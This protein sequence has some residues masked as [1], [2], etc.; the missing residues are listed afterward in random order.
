MNVMSDTSW[1]SILP[2][3]VAIA[4]AIRSKQVYIS[5]F[6]GVYL[7][8]I[9]LS[10]WNPLEGAAVSLEYLIRVFADGGN[11]SI[12]LFCGLVGGL[13]ALTQHSGGVDGFV[14]TL[15]RRGGL[16]NRRSAQLMSGIMGTM[17]FVETSISSLVVGAVSR[18]VFDRM[19][20]SREK[21]AFIC[22][23][24]CAPINLLIP[25]NAWGAFIIGLLAKENIP[26]PV[27]VLITSLGFNFYALAAVTIVFILILTGK[28]F[29]PMKKAEQRARETGKVQADDAKPVVSE[30]VI[31][32]KRAP[33]IKPAASNML[34]P[35]VTMILMMPVGLLVTGKGDLTA[36]SGSTSVLWAVLSATIA[37][38]VWYRVKGLMKTGKMMDIIVKGIGGMVPIMLLMMLAFAI[39]DV[40]RAL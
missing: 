18:P 34:I 25:L 35:I 5:L 39:G 27:G 33:S 22:D 3:V 23:S 30:E 6:A 2:P 37:A 4:L 21:L 20:I 31:G 26:E 17:I 29:G 16:K 9:I 1:I 10:N 14:D 11:T 7:G 36:G 28:D 38:V 24:T 8:C 40:T 15:S 12:I 32:I 13:I 19:K